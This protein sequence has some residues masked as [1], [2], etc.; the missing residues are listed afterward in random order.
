MTAGAAQAVALAR[1]AGIDPQLVLD[2]IK[3]GPA[4][5]PYLQ[6]KGKAM[7]D[8]NYPVAFHPGRRRQACRPDGGHGHGYRSQPGVPP[9]PAIDAGLGHPARVR[10]GTWP[11]CTRSSDVGPRRDGVHHRR[12]GII[13]GTGTGRGS[14]VAGRGS[15][16]SDSGAERRGRRFERDNRLRD[17]DLDATTGPNGPC[18]CK[19]SAVHRFA[20]ASFSGSGNSM[21]TVSGHDRNS[22]TAGIARQQHSSAQNAEKGTSQGGPLFW[23]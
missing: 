12:A 16:E 7:I 1:H 6:I 15:R 14:R 17:S 3:G 4:D 11:R 23:K 22:T 2:T 10:P 8:R 9:R 21:T 5:T 19:V 20:G 18:A 13:A